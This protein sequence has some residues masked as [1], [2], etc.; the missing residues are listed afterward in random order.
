MWTVPFLFFVATCA[1]D[2]T[3]PVVGDNFNAQ[4]DR[5]M[6]NG[7]KESW[8]KSLG[9]KVSEVVKRSSQMAGIVEK[10]SKRF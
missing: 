3:L 4:A 5:S 8:F 9:A 6:N 1:N 2:S 10:S 7:R